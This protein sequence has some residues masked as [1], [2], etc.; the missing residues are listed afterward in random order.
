MAIT[1]ITTKTIESEIQIGLITSHHNHVIFPK[2]F[3]TIKTMVNKPTKPIPPELDE[4]E[5]PDI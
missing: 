4:D 1:Q 3:K 5:L 2:S